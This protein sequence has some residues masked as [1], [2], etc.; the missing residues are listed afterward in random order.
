MAKSVEISSFKNGFKRIKKIELEQINNSKIREITIGI[1]KEKRKEE[2][3]IFKI[4]K[5]VWDLM[6]NCF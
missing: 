5:N 3:I 6:V 1:V 4:K 2:N